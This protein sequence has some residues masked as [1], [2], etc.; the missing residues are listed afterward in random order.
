MTV[1]I[2]ANRGFSAPLAATPGLRADF[3]NSLNHWC[4]LVRGAPDAGDSDNDDQR[5]ATR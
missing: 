1:R 2:G 4:E 3:F 5:A